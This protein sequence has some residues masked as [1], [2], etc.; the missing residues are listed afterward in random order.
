MNIICGAN[1]IGKTNFLRALDLFFTLDVKRFVYEDDMPYHKVHGGG[2]GNTKSQIIVTFLD[3]ENDEKIEINTT[4]KGGFKKN[5]SLEISGKRNKKDI[6]E[7]D[8]KNIV[9]SFRFFFIQSNNINLPQLIR[10]IFKDQI[11]PSIDSKKSKGKDALEKLEGF[12]EASRVATKGIADKLSEHLKSFI[13]DVNGLDSSNWRLK[14]NFPNF[15]I[16]REAISDLVDFTLLD[17]NDN[18]FESKGGGTQRMVLF[19][20]ISYIAEN[21]DKKT[22][23]ALDEP[24]AFLQPGLQKKLFSD[25]TAFV[26]KDNISIILTT[27][28]QH[29]I[30]IESIENTYLFDAETEQKKYS[31]RPKQSFIEIKT[32]LHPSTG[33]CKLLAIK[34]HMGIAK[35]DAWDVLPFNLLVEGETDKKYLTILA[36]HF[37]IDVPNILVAG[38]ADSMKGHLV[39][40]AGF[41]NKLHFKPVIRCILDNDKK[42]KEVCRKIEPRQY[43]GKMTVTKYLIKRFDN[44]R[45]SKCL[46]EIEDFI[47]PDVIIDAANQILRQKRQKII[48]KL[49]RENRTKEVYNKKRILEFLDEMARHNNPES[50]VVSFT[51]GLKKLLCRNAC[52]MIRTEKFDLNEADQE[53]PSVRKNL[54]NLM[55]NPN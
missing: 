22:I 38:G 44:N 1:N 27:H 3:C 50:E 39:F 41:V 21:A 19:S 18:S 43:S 7:T 23:W 13:T 5:S 45:D 40:L 16:L 12:F 51:G 47:Y 36:E 49:Q 29:F 15:D 48:T 46:F 4:F 37:K 17:N 11:L 9:N 26:E 54:K 8:C 55:K 2:G 24:E 31:K 14:I 10:S 28:S 52:E 35:N 33:V 32:K 30:D 34:K 53:H 20:L 6:T 25:L 42:G